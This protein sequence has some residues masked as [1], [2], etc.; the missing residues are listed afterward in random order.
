MSKKNL[1][2]NLYSD[3]NKNIGDNKK[4]VTKA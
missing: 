4:I 1:V 3:M 2:I